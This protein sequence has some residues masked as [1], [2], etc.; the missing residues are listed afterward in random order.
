MKLQRRV[1]PGFPR[2]SAPSNTET[3]ST[4][5]RSASPEVVALP[6]KEQRSSAKRKGSGETLASFLDSY[7]GAGTVQFNMRMLVPLHRHYSS[8]VRQCAD[9]NFKTS[10]TEIFHALLHEGPAS[11]AE[12]QALVKRWRKQLLDA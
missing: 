7:R 3:E 2:T 5:N 6:S 4:T 10:A 9:E 12:I 1:P 8:L 11:A